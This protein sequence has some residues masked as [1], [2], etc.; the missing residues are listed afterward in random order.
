MNCYLLG[1]K[2]G[3]LA[4]PSQGSGRTALQML[5]WCSEVVGID[6]VEYEEIQKELTCVF[7]KKLHMYAS[8]Q[9][10]W[11]KD[12]CVICPSLS[13]VFIL[14]DG[15]KNTFLLSTSIS[16]AIVWEQYY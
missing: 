11:R 12:V 15:G 13:L 10:T 9:E 16:P 14:S 2:G 3:T 8:D 5:E 6:V 1:V 7:I 4:F